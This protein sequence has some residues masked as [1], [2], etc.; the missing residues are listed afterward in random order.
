M[1]DAELLDLI[2]DKCREA[3]DQAFA[4]AFIE[5]YGLT[6]N[7]AH[8]RLHSAAKKLLSVEEIVNRYRDCIPE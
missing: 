7:Q 5:K 3:D 2:L 4:K 6:D 1:D 8:M